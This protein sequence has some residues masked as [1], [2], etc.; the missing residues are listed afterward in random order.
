MSFSA[1]TAALSTAGLG[2]A[3]SSP[4]AATQIPAEIRKQGARAESAYAEGLAFEQVLVSQLTRQLGQTAPDPSSGGTDASAS[5]SLFGAGPEAGEYSPLIDQAVTQ[6]LMASG[7]LGIA[8][9]IARAIDPS[10]R[11]T[12]G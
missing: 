6:S 7:G 4:V 5:S 8:G 2:M 10:I 11:E 12:A 3:G 9:E 1:P